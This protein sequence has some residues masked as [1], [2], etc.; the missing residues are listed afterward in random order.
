MAQNKKRKIDG[1]LS[2]FI[3]LALLHEGK[4]TL[5]QLKERTALQTLNFHS[6]KE[7]RHS[8]PKEDKKI[9]MTCDGLVCK[10]WLQL[11]DNAE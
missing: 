8:R 5:S 1:D 6:H 9:E 2:E 4:L 3:L 10:K 11:T 7:I